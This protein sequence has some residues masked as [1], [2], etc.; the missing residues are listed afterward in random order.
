M[1]SAAIVTAQT[2]NPVNGTYSGTFIDVYGNN[3]PV[4]TVLSQSA[5]DANGNFVLSG[6][7]NVPAG[8]GCFDTPTG[9]DSAQ[10]TGQQFNISYTDSNPGNTLMTSGSVSTDATTLTVGS[11][12]IQGPCSGESGTGG[13]LTKQ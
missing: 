1:S 7:A 9:T 2:V 3:I 8:N 5:A 10:V 6:Y 12:S 13:T 11:W 4:S